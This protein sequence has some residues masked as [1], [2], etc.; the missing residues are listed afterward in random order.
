MR[1]HL[2]VVINKPKILRKF[3]KE[4]ISLDEAFDRAKI[5]NIEQRLKKIR[6]GLNDIEKT[7]IN[8]LEH[9]EL[10]AAQ[11][12]VRHIRRDLCRVSDMIEAKTTA[13]KG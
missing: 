1:D 2:P 12:V 10:K 5:S 6:E 8:V 11:L 4:S 13:M 3:E 7:D 9:N